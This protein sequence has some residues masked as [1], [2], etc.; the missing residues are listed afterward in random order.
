MKKFIEIITLIILWFVITPL[1]IYLAKR[2]KML[3]LKVSIPLAVISP[4]V[5]IIIG[6]LIIAGYTFYLD[7]HRTHHFTNKEVV[8][9]ITSIQLPDF[10][11]INYQKGKSAFT[12]DYSDDVDILFE[13]EIADSTFAF[14]DSII[15]NGD[16]M[17]RKSGNKYV[18]STMWGNGLT[19][20]PGEDKEY[21][22][23]FSLQINKGKREATIQH[24]SW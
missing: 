13:T 15:N 8:E 18:Y 5:L 3:K 20:P 17:W 7:F 19:P 14:L 12:G 2:W 4:L 9:C 21:D 23:F 16:K 22:G 11:V 24:G 6:C 1:F 10:E